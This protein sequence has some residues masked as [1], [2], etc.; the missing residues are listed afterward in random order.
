MIC[1]R[2]DAIL[3]L[4]TERPRVVDVMGLPLCA[5]DTSG[6]IRLLVDR[7]T[8]K[9]PSRACYVNA[10]VHNLARRNPDL[11][12]ALATSDVLYADGMSMVWASRLL[13]RPLPARLSSADY[14][15]DFALASAARG[16]SLFLLGGA[17]G[18]AK[19]AAKRLIEWVPDL[20]IVGVHGGYFDR[21]DNAAVVDRI[22]RA[23]PDILLVGMGSPGQEIWSAENRP[24]LDVPVIWCVGALFD[25]LAGQEWRAPEW[26]CRAG[27]EWAYRLAMDPIGKGRRYLVGNPLFAGAVTKAWVRQILRRDDE[28][29]AE[30]EVPSG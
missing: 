15:E 19:R 20:R 4:A 13:G 29:P 11:R 18:V 9:M 17:D 3:D 26:M 8:A 16:T 21:A 27:L 23:R 2:V 30:V 12:D 28:R 5:V 10:H 1:S 14:V 25:Y 22:N 24:R 6:L 7:A